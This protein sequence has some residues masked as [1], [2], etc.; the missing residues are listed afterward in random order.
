MFIS[1]D[2]T[3]TGSVDV[4]RLGQVEPKTDEARAQHEALMRD[5]RLGAE[6]AERDA[7]RASQ[8]ERAL[9]I[10]STGRDDDEAAGSD[11]G[12]GR[13]RAEQK[14]DAERQQADN[15]KPTGQDPDAELEQLRGEAEAAGVTVDKR[16]GT[17]RLRQETAAA[18]A[19]QGR[20]R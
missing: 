15:E 7:S 20:K 12:G 3:V 18:Q 17:D 10:N 1:E 8:G 14:A 6:Q 9:G 13:S 16:W 11:S 5:Q 4:S 19:A 2:G